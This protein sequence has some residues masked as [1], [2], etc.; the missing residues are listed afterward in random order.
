M[1]RWVGLSEA[2][3]RKVVIEPWPDGG[4]AVT[5]SAGPEER[6]VLARRFGLLELAAL[7]A[8]LRLERLPASGE[9]RLHGVLEADLTQVCVVSLEPVPAQLRE[10]VER[11]YRR[12]GGPAPAAT[13]PKVWTPDEDEDEEVELVHGRTLDLGAALAEELALAL[14]PYPRAPDAEALLAEALAADGLGPYISF[15]AATPAEP[16]LAALRQL[17]EK[18]AR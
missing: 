2:F 3:A 16:P 11:R 13:S 9:I 17:K 15:G 18:R 8:R 12:A 14:D 4:I 7:E 5:L 6:A 1:E 10:P